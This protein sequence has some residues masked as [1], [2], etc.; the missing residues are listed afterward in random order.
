MSI[1]IEDLLAAAEAAEKR[2]NEAGQ[3]LHGERV[4]SM[5]HHAALKNAVSGMAAEAA[6]AVKP[7]FDSYDAYGF[8]R[9]GDQ[10]KMKVACYSKDN[11]H[12]QDVV[13]VSLPLNAVCMLKTQNE[14]SN[15]TQSP[16]SPSTPRM[17]P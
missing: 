9:N 6:R 10:M 4:A 5:A 16:K 17:R 2:A 15:D 11:R 12:T 3:G 13:D 7:N 1:K 14:A 8:E